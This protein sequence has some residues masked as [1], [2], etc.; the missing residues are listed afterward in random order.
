MTL[1]QKINRLQSLLEQSKE[2]EAKATPD[3]SFRVWKDHAVSTLGKVLSPDSPETIRVKE[4]TFTYNRGLRIRGVDYSEVDR[5]SR[6]RRYKHDFEVAVGII[7]YCLNDFIMEQEEQTQSG[8]PSVNP[9][10][11]FSLAH[12][13]PTVQQAAS[14]RFASAH[15]A[16]AI[17][18]TCTALDKAVAAK[19]QRPDLNG[20]QLMDVAFT[21]RNP[22][23]RLSQNDNEQTG[24]MLLYQGS[25]QAI[26]NHY[27][28]NLTEIPA[29]RALEWLGFISALFYKLDEAQPSAT[30]P[31]P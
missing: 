27:A 8:S 21:P 18:A 20:K 23:V 6:I 5:E 9:G 30:T 3:A 24:F 1:A 7:R 31:T 25:V 2:H 14:S 15:Y 29:A 11:T 19:T 13:H 10:L 16:D 26:R 4:L 12:L 22:L 28:H 17:S